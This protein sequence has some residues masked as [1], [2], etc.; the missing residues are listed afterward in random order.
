MI[1]PTALYILSGL[2]VLLILAVAFIG[3]QSMRNTRDL[4]A[5]T[6]DRKRHVPTVTDVLAST[7]EA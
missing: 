5:H 7:I 6:Q 3:A 4:A 2:I 1:I